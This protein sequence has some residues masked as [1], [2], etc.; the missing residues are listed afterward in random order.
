MLFGWPKAV[1]SRWSSVS[2]CALHAPSP[3]FSNAQLK[4][5]S[6]SLF[7][8][9]TDLCRLTGARVL[10]PYY[11]LAPEFQWPAQL[12]ETFKCYKA[13]VTE[14]GVDPNNIVVVGMLALEL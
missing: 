4:L 9:R 11:K 2:S 6:I 3:S 14:E 5:W 12:T 1:E 8:E 7:F 10:A 13:L